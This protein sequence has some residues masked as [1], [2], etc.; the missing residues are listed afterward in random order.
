[1]VSSLQSLVADLHNELAQMR[2]DQRSIL[3]HL[4]QT[5][6]QNQQLCTQILHQQKQQQQQHQQQK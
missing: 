1:M 2:V 5:Q 6:Q 3:T 4:S